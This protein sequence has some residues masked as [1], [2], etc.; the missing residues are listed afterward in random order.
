M[1]DFDKN[2]SF[3]AV[4]DG[5]GGAEV[6]LYCAQNLPKFLKIHDEYKKGNYERALQLAFIDFD[7][8]LVQE[9][10]IEELKKLIPVGNS[11]E[12]E[13][14]EDEDLDELTHEGQLPLDQLLEKYK[15]IKRINPALAK[16]K[17]S[18]ASGSKPI[19]PSLRGR[20]AQR[21]AEAE[22][23]GEGSSSGGGSSSGSKVSSSKVE[24]EG[25]SSSAEG[26]TETA[27][28]T[29]DSSSTK[30]AATNGD[31]AFKSP[32][33]T[34]SNNSTV[35]P[36]SSAAAS[37]TSPSK[38]EPKAKKPAAA[39]DDDSSSEDEEDV[40]YGNASDEEALAADSDEDDEEDEDDDDEDDDDDDDD[41]DGDE[42]DDEDMYPGEDDDEG[43]LNNM[44]EA[45]GSSSGC[46]AVVALL[47]DRELFVAN[48][49]DSRCVVCRD[50]K[51]LEMSLDHKPEDTE[52]LERIKKAGGRVT[53]D[54]RVNGG[55]NLSRAI[56][57]HG[58]K[59]NKELKPEEQM[60][61]AKPDI[62]R[63]TISPT[64]EFM[65]IACDGIWNFMTSDEVVDFVK[66]R[67]N[68]GREKLSTICEEVS[69]LWLNFYIF[70]SSTN[71]ICVQPRLLFLILLYNGSS[72]G[73]TPSIY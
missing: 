57:D 46:T 10:I 5:H 16:V 59:M 67:I 54:G 15:E 43:F 9:T 56:G 4:Y 6:A 45:P 22:Q 21:S 72:S 2:A 28:A 20:R 19:S 23:N 44:V 24:E 34:I 8:T 48:A 51:A 11:R 14:D 38:P 32:D 49:G 66:V 42:S 33:T 71:N 12:T 58:Y 55:L 63:I 3:F 31:A 62:K 1:L 36:A 41:E 60:I 13:T 18:D 40:T 61:S 7:G 73:Q 37:T 69:L 53:L 68:D 47:V 27:D 65:V 25:V 29:P 30:E 52:E 64:D 70:M 39:D 35:S 17:E 50:G 26:K